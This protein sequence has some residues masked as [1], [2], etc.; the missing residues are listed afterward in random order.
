[1]GSR[2]EVTGPTTVGRDAGSG[3]RLERDEFASARHARIEPRPDG[4][5]IEDLG[6]TI[7]TL[8]NDAQIT[9][10]RRL[11]TDDVVKVG[12][13]ELRLLA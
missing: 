1:V 7:G 3:I 13:T 9:G 5:W 2:L 4:V 8:V 10:T 6:S 11:V 12:A